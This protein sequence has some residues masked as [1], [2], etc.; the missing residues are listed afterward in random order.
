M[1]SSR[2]NPCVAHAKDETADFIKNYFSDASKG[3]TLIAGAG[4][5][6]RAS[7]VSHALSDACSDLNCVLIKEHRPSPDK[8]QV[9]QA[10]QNRSAMLSSV[11][12]IEFVDVEI[13]GDDGAVVGAGT[14]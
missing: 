7:I 3:V 13:F 6:P 10:D 5:D 4:F 1:L 11:Q 12:H 8:A 9:S 14:P 2:W